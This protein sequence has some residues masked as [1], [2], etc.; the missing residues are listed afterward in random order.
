MQP[1]VESATPW[2]WGGILNS[3]KSGE[4]KLSI[5]K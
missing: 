1:T 3:L 2:G 4:N 5:S